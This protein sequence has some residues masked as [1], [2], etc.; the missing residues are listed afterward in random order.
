MR[1]AT[2][3]VNSLNVRQERVE[4]WLADIAPDAFNRSR[5]FSEY[6]EHTTLIDEVA[7]VANLGPDVTLN[8]CLGR[9]ATSARRFSVD[10]V[11][12]CRRLAP[13]VTALAER[14]WAELSTAVSP[15]EDT[16]DLLIRTAR[17]RHGMR[18]TARQAEVA[19]LILRGH[20]SLSIGLRLGVSPQTVKVFRRQLYD[21]CKISSQAEL[22]A[23]MVPMLKDK[24]RGLDQGA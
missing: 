12:A 22:F 17:K 3:N 13:V 11:E 15:S 6:Y 14:Q 18:L 23:L 24:T 7:F 16:V 10:E 20:S 9:D 19:I 2:W 4:Q 8:L 21:R 5:Y 1:F